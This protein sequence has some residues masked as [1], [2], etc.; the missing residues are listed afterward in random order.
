MNVKEY[1]LPTKDNAQNS[2]TNKSSESVK[3]TI[4]RKPSVVLIEWHA[5]DRPFKKKSRDFYRRVAVILI[6]FSLLFL[7]IKDFWLILF[8]GLFFFVV[9]VF[10]S[11]P[12]RTV[13]HKITTNG[14]KYASER[15]YE[16][17]ELVDFFFYKRDGVDFLVFDTVEKFP[18]RL[19]LI[20]PDKTLKDKIR[21]VV[22]QYLSIID[23]PDETY[24]DKITTYL[25]RLFH[26]A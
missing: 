8:M 1:L 14:V 21:N 24:L 3:G 15:T 20:L 25:S 18:G 10:T 5:P 2:E 12:P 23:T 26:F 17:S 4:I 6:F 19:Y 7:I 9:Y 16:W 11:I 22:N 13:T